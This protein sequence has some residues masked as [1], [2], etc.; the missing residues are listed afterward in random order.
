MYHCI[1]KAYFAVRSAVQC[2]RILCQITQVSPNPST[3]Q[4]Y[5]I[6]QNKLPDNTYVHIAYVT[7]KLTN[8]ILP[9]I[10]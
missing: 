1:S 7:L 5:T 10:A 4:A 9:T 2:V 3:V 6:Q 8:I